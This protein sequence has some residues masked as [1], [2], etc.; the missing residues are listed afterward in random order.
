MDR[1]AETHHTSKEIGARLRRERQQQK[2]SV[3]ELA[4]RI[5]SDPNTVSR[6]ETGKRRVTVEWLSTLCEAL[7]LR[8]SELL[9]RAK[10]EERVPVKAAACAN[11]WLEEC[12]YGADKRYCLQVPADPRYPEAERFAVEGRCPA[13][14]LR[15][16][17]RSLLI[18]VPLDAVEEG[19]EIDKRYL[20]ETRRMR[21]GVEESE[22]SVKTLVTDSDN[23]LH[24]TTESSDPDYQISLPVFGCKDD[25]AQPIARVIGSVQPE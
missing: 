12:W 15:Y 8:A 6:L 7:G 14:N 16:P 18:C 9:E 5:G 11:R 24:F 4:R 23:R 22:L 20:I 19:V 1:A 25:E 13:M 10:P 21:D 2:I 17:E 3:R